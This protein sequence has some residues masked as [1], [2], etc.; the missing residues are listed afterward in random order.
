MAQRELHT[1]QLETIE[2]HA[3]GEAGRVVINA[4]DL[5]EGATMAERFAYCRDHLDGLRRFLLRE[6]RGFPGLCAVLVLPPVEPGSDLG[7]VVLEQGGF[8]AMSGSNTICT[9]TAV[10]ESGIVPMV[11]PVT[12]VRIDTAVGLVEAEAVVS[13]GKV[14]SV[15]VANVPSFV[16]GLD[17]PLEV[18]TFGTVAVD[19]V[20]GGGFFVQ[21]PAAAL[22]LEIHP[23]KGRELTRAGALLKLAALEQLD[24][25]HP[26]NPDI[27]SVGNV[28]LHSGDRQPGVPD[29]NAV[30]LTQG[31]LRAD[32]PATWTGAL[33]RS[34]C[35]TGTCG[36]MAALHARS[37]LEI[38]EK[39][40]HLSTI[41]TEFVGELLGTTTLG[42][43]DAV[44]P[45]ITGSAWVTGRSTWV[46]DP[47]D[48]FPSGFS[49]GDIWA[50][51]L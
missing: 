36:R 22:G 3:E 45:T 25:R 39:F 30:V 41:G 4:A 19:V 10:L 1:L 34:P 42:P 31:P 51:G 32:D 35:G 2:A 26:L 13:G 43:Y 50:P 38:G 28:M 6:P 18:P 12:R 15:T 7:I 16:V 21:A 40:S 49:V 11:E 24:L 8:T 44:L 47:T 5:V 14:R 37:Q 20:F 48:P 29:R 27:H 23:D 33:D 17:V 46:L 9:V